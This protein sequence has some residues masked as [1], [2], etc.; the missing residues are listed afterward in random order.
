MIAEET[1]TKSETVRPRVQSVARAANILFAVAQSPAGLTSREIS[2]KVG[3][4]RQATYHLLHTLAALGLLTRN[5]RNRHVMG[6]RICSLAEGFKRQLAPTEY[7]AP[8]IRQIADATGETAYAAGWWNGEIVTLHLAR[9]QNAVQAAEV[10]QGLTGSAHAR[11]AGKLLLAFATNVVRDEYF[12]Q[13]PLTPRTRNT[14]TT[15]AAL[16]GEFEKIKAQGYSLDLEEFAEGLSCMAVPID[17]GLSPFALALTAPVDRFTNS[18][19]EYLRVMISIANQISN[20][21][22]LSG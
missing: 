3:L 15:H 4:P 2:E 20:A 11:A 21:S 10:P 9:G 7:L 18:R 8:Y 6:L 17:G 1:E 16:A 14:L 19:D 22:P 5:Q 13:H 12:K